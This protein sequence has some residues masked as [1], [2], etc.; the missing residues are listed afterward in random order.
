MRVNKL[1]SLTN[2]SCHCVIEGYAAQNPTHLTLTLVQDF[3]CHVRLD[4]FDSQP[5]EKQRNPSNK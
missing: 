1:P 2:F 5:V 3:L 4:M